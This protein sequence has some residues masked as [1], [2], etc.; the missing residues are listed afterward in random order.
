MV[1]YGFCS[2]DWRYTPENEPT[3]SEEKKTLM[4]WQKDEG[5]LCFGISTSKHLENLSCRVVGEEG[6]IC[7]LSCVE[8][9]AGYIG[10]G[11]TW[12]AIPKGPNKEFY[13]LLT[14]YHRSSLKEGSFQL[15]HL[16]CQ[17]THQSGIF[18]GTIILS[19]EG[20]GVIGKLNFSVEVLALDYTQ[21]DERLFDLELWEYPFSVARFY[22]ISEEEW[23]GA[24]HQ[25][26]LRENLE[27]YQKAG[28]RT[29]AVTITHDPWAHQ[30][31][32]TCY[33]LI[34]WQRKNGKFSYDF[35]LFDQYVQLNMAMGID[36]TIKSFSLLP[37]KN[38]VSYFD[39][40]HQLVTQIIEPGSLEWTQ[41]WRP[42]LIAYS[43][44][45]E[46]KGWFEK[47]YIAMDEAPVEILR[48]AVKLVK[49]VK[50]ARGQ[51]L[52]LACAINY[53]AFDAHFLNEF[54][55]I[56]INMAQVGNRE[57]FI[58]MVTS[59]KI[60]N[61]K[62]TLYNCVGDYP[63]MFVYSDPQETAF[64]LWYCASLKTTGFLRWALDAWV[65]DPVNSLNHWFWESGDSLLIYPHRENE[66]H[67]YPSLRFQQL[68]QGVI[69]VRKYRYLQQKDSAKIKEVTE[70]LSKMILPEGIE[71]EWKAK[72]AKY[73]ENRLLIHTQ[74]QQ[75]EEALCR[76]SQKFVSG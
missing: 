27:L 29:I 4:L 36:Q 68:V 46:E 10:R 2:I 6:L 3:F 33:S 48:D 45:L 35:S 54:S 19:A 75:L 76:A 14:P 11:M 57:M 34:K 44:H 18:S 31:Y 20:L 66:E 62:T 39:E 15:Y 67:P 63:S 32:D 38:Q 69:A 28:G 1:R 74:V 5:S 61:Q 49:S 64:I 12:G 59:R 52:K 42:F 56:S 8:K 71:N 43:Q 9:T 25:K 53:Q 22:G 70:L 37:W 55:D 72:V 23:L 40:N 24:R 73:P 26:Y 50:N 13:D 51:H 47:T 16:S 58:E 60:K 21:V 7:Q 65:E 30:T 17:S 41:L